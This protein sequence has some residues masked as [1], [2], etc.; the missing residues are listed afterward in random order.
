[1]RISTNLFIVILVSSI[2]PALIAASQ[3]NSDEP[4]PGT[5]RELVFAG[6]V[7]GYLDDQQNEFVVLPGTHVEVMVNG[8]N[9][10]YAET[11]SDESGNFS[12]DADYPDSNWPFF[13][14]A[15]AVVTAEGYYQQEIT[16][17]FGGWPVLID[18]YL[19]PFETVNNILSGYVYTLSE[20]DG[21]LIPVPGALV[22]IF[23]GLDGGLLSDF[24]TWESGYFEFGNIAYDADLIIVSADGFLPQEAPLPG[25]SDDPLEL[26]FILQPESDPSDYGW[27]SGDVTASLS[28]DETVYPIVGAVIGAISTWGDP[29]WYE[30]STNDLGQYELDLPA[31]DNSW[32]ISCTSVFGIQSTEVLIEP[33]AELVLDFH[34][35]A[36]EYPPLPPPM[37]L[38]ADLSEDESLVWLNWEPPIEWPSFCAAQYLISKNIMNDP[39][40][41]W[42]VIG[43]TSELGWEDFPESPDSLEMDICYRVTSFCEDMASAPGNISCVQNWEAPFPPAPNGLTA[44]HILEP[45][46]AGSVI[47]DW[48]YPIIPEP[49]LIPLFQVYAHLGELSGNEFIY[50]GETTELHYEYQ[51]GDFVEPDPVNCFRINALMEEEL[52]DYSNTACVY[53]EDEPP[54][55]FQ[56]YG[57]VYI[58][59]EVQEMIADAVIQAYDIM[60]GDEYETISDESGHYEL[61]VEPGEYII[62]CTVDDDLLQQHHL[63]LEEDTGLH[64]DFWSGE[65]PE[66]HILTGMIFGLAATG[67]LLPLSDAELMAVQEG[68]IL[69]TSSNAGIYEISL[70]WSGD[71]SVLIQ[72]TGF[73]DFYQD[74]WLEENAEQDFILAPL[75][76]LYPVWLF[77][78]SNTATPGDTVEIEL[79]IENSE[80]ISDITFTLF[81]NPPWLTFIDMTS[82]LDCFTSLV[83]GKFGVNRTAISVF[84]GR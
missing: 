44:V 50:V 14:E 8:G 45:E 73:E 19:L 42:F 48:Y 56:L 27:I 81:H 1:M 33:L 46:P 75:E 62:T 84:P 47:L 82:Q 3:F 4:E 70:P 79:T 43:E 26:D 7:F 9:T 2:F 74:I 51:F 68:I 76:D 11:W 61:L 72:A 5:S 53:L 40:H 37:S 80:S 57:N 78:G 38:T 20:P 25:Y 63:I 15:Q 64:L 60:S 71:W 54:G 28:P 31:S 58:V 39:S 41:D 24:T 55:E 32:L 67:D 65:F 12:F 77:T 69:Y 17:D 6:T 49:G 18:F 22:E 34:F 52:S 30:T 23:D 83:N 21:N 66:S 13:H 10:F 59:G 16:I 29:I 36:W 35:N